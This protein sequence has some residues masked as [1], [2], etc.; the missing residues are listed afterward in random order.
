MDGELHELSNRNRRARVRVVMA[1][2]TRI[3]L[4]L[5]LLFSCCA[6]STALLVGVALLLKFAE[7]PLIDS[8]V[9]QVRTYR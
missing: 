7:E 9:T 4:C 8:Q 3:P 1:K 5:G 6:L 2:E